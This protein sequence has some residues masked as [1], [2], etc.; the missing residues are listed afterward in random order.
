MTTMT[1]PISALLCAAALLATTF[2]KAETFD[3]AEV[4]CYD[5]ARAEEDDAIALMVWIDGF[6]AGMAEDTRFNEEWI[7]RLAL[8]VEA[9]CDRNP[10]QNLRAIIK[11]IR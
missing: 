3:V 11:R 8:D 7:E 2:A 5:L 6:L 4:T 9:E 10:N 1:K